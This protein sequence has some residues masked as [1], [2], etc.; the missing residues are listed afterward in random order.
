MAINVEKYPTNIRPPIR[1]N[2]SNAHSIEAYRADINN[3]VVITNII[4]E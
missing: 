2:L 4:M 1:T 3:A